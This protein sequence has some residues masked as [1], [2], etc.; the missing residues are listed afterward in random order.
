MELKK[1]LYEMKSEHKKLLNYDL[2]IEKI[3]ME[4]GLEKINRTWKREEKTT[5]EVRVLEM[6]DID[7]DVLVLE[8][9]IPQ[10]DEQPHEEDEEDED[11]GNYKP[12]KVGFSILMINFC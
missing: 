5:T 7:E 12:V 4:R 6:E 3:K 10:A 11:E 8:D 2:R 1:I 9:Q